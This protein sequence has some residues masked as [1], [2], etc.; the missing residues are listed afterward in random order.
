M[1]LSIVDHTDIYH[2]DGQVRDENYEFSAFLGSKMRMGGVWCMDC[3]EPHSAK[4]RMPGNWLCM[5]C[6]D[7]GMTNAPVIHPVEHSHH[8]VF[9][10]DSKGTL[11]NF[12]VA[13]YSADGIAETGGECINCHMPQTVYMQRHW[14]HDH[15]FTIPDPQLTA[16]FAIPNACNRC[17]ADKST[18]WAVEWSEKWYGEKL[19]RPSRTRTRW[20]ARAR[21]SDSAAMDPLVRQLKDEA[22][23]YWR[24]VAANLLGQ[25]AS[26]PQVLDALITGL[27]D[28]N[29]LVRVECAGALGPLA[30]SGHPSATEALRDA[31]LDDSRSVRV[32]AGWALR[33]T[34]DPASRAGS[35]V[36]H[37]LNLNADQPT[38]QL[39][40]GLYE[41]ARGGTNA[42][43]HF[44]KA[45]EWD[46]YSPPLR[47]Q[48]ATALSV[49]ERHAEALAELQKA[50]ELVPKDAEVRFQLA[51]A[52]N[53]QGDLAGAAEQLR[54][55]VELN[56]RH[57][58]A[59]YNLGL[60]QNALKQTDL[61]L[62]SLARAEAEAPMDWRAPYARATI[63]LT[64]GRDEEARAALSRVLSIEPNHSDAQRLLER[65]R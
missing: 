17:H 33:A 14:R 27:G 28:T 1:R 63:L 21:Q 7:G 48:L 12:N 45:V 25:W 31:L 35:E 52:L 19:E 2:P 40:K 34:L 9:G 46:P 56:P 24:A 58:R 29:A 13:D 15:G 32:A 50:A 5:R 6:H 54:R 36:L 30:E 11:T 10:Y 49:A 20:V 61:A 42:I 39:Q 47:M 16:E 26:S 59:W 53:E 43:S 64:L 44:R 60:A 3:H 51:L 55:A 38:G 18:E 57:A 22:N 8:K 4:R 37:S 62:E 23:P 41:A 65:V